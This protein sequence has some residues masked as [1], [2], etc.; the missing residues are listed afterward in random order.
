M[1]TD[2]SMFEYKNGW[3]G[4]ILDPVSNKNIIV[5]IS[6]SD[7]KQI[8]DECK[9]ALDWFVENYEAMHDELLY[10]ILEYYCD[11]RE[12]LGYD[13]EENE[14]YPFVSSIDEISNMITFRAITIPNQQRFI[15]GVFLV[16]D[17]SWDIEEGLG[18]RIVD[19]QITRVGNQGIAL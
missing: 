2:Y 12:N 13:V 9:E 3:Y 8:P 7:S 17:C 6:S 11:E 4:N 19:G 1:R 18:I 16:Y 15:K 10:K 14:D 5:H